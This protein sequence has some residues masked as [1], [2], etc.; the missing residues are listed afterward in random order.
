MDTSQKF[1]DGFCS[2]YQPTLFVLNGLGRTF[3]MKVCVKKKTIKKQNMVLL[4]YSHY[5]LGFRVEN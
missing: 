3:L 4:S 1:G 2:L 5:K